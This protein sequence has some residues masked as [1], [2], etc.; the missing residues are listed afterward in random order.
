MGVILSLLLADIAVAQLSG[1]SFR[2]KF[3]VNSGQVSGSSDLN[4]FPV[5]VSVTDADLRSTGNGGNVE[6]PNGF[7][8]TFT[9]S[10]GTTRLDHQLE[11]YDASTGEV[12][13]WVRFPTLSATSDTEF[14]IYYGNSGI[15]T[16]QSAASTFDS[17]YQL[18]SHLNNSVNDNS[19]NGFTGTANATTAAPGFIGGG[20]SFGGGASDFISYTDD[21]AL[22][23]AGDI[24]I[25]M[26]VNTD[27]IN[28]PDLLTKGDFDDAY[29]AWFDFNGIIQFQINA[30]RLSGNG[31]IS[32]GNWT[33]L[34][35]VKSSGLG[36]RAIF[37][38]GA[39]DNSDGTTTAF[40]TNPDPLTISSSAF[41]FDGTID[42]VRISDVA[43]STDWISTEFNNQNAPAAFI[44][45][46]PDPP[47]LTNIE[48]DPQTFN[49]GGSPVFV[50][51]SIDIEHP[52][53][54]TLQ[55]GTVEIT[56]NQISSEDELLFTD[57]NGIT[58]S[59]NSGNGILS[60]S[61]TAS[62]ADYQ[63]ALRSIQYN[64]TNGTDPDQSTR[65]ISFTVNDGS[66]N[67]NTVNR[68]LDIIKSITDLSTDVPEVVFHFD[69][70]D[71]DGDLQTTDQPTDGSAIT[72]WGD[73]SDDATGS[74]IDL[75]AGALSGAE[76]PLFDSAFFGERGGLLWDGTDDG[77]E[78]PDDNS[79]NT[80]S[81]D[82]K[83]FAVIFRTGASTAGLQ[84]VYEQGAGTRGY[85]ISIK[86][87]QAYAYTWNKA[88][89]GAGD[90]NKSINL[91][92]VQPHE[93][94]IVIASHDAAQGPLADRTWSAS[95]NGGPLQTLNNT[96]VQEAHG[97]DPVIGKEDG[98]SDP[99]TFT[100][101]A[102]TGNFDGF[103]AELI[104]WNSALNGGQ[105]SSIYTFLDDKWGNIPPQLSSIENTDLDYTEGDPPTIITSNITVSDSDNTV[106]DSAYVTITE[107]FASTEDALSFTSAGNITG[108]F[109]TGTG[110]LTLKGRD[111]KANYQT[112]LRSVTY[113]NT[114]TVDPATALRQVDFK[115]FDWDDSSNAASRNINIISENSSPVISNIEG[116]T[117]PY[118]EGDGAVTVTSSIT[119]NDADNAEL[120]SADISITD[121]FTLGEDKLDFPDQNGI[122]GNFNSSTG[123][124]TLT[125]TASVT[126]YQTALRSVT[127]ENISSD[128]VEINRTISLSVNDGNSNSN[129]LSRDVSVTAVNTAPALSN[130][131]S[132]DLTFEGS[133]I[134]ITNTLNV[135]DPDD[136][137]L[138]SALV[139]I[140]EN[141]DNSQDSLRFDPIFGISGSWD[142]GTGVLKLTGTAQLSDYQAA[143]Q[144]VQ[145]DNFAGIP[146]GAQREI[147]FVASDGLAKSDTVK[148]FLNVTAVLAIPDATVWLRADLGITTSGSE[149]VEWADQTENGNDYSGNAGTG[150]RPSLVGSSTELNN[151]PAVNFSGDG[152]HFLDS[153]GH[154]N[155]ING[156][157]EFTMFI[158]IKSDQ[159]GTDSGFWITETPVG[160]DKTF[161][162]RY[163]D[164]GANNNG[165]FTNVV[166]T[167]ILNNDPDNQLESFSNLQT[168]NG[169]ILSLNW[170]SNSAYDI[171]VDGILNNPSAAGP[172][173]TGIIS[174]ATTAILGKGG[175]DQGNISWD[176]QIAEFILFSRNITDEERKTVEDYLSEKY[177]LPIRKIDPAD[178]GEAISADDTN[179]NFTTLTGPTVQE[180]VPGELSAGGTLVFT[181]PDGF[182]WNTG[183]TPSVTVSA[184]FGGNT[185][186][187]ASFTSI[188]ATEITFTINT[189]S[190]S[191]PGQ[192][193]FS[194]LQVRPTNGVLPNTGNI[195]NTGSTGLGGDT[196]YG[197][198]NMVAGARDSLVYLQQPTNTIADS[199]ISPAV[200]LQLADQFGNTVKDQGVSIDLALTSGSGT[201]S[202]TTPILTNSLGISEFS[203]LS[204]DQ[205]GTKQL[206]ASGTGLDNS[207]SSE[208]DILTAGAL[209]AFKIEREPSGNISTQQ[210]GQNF[211]I[212]ITAIDGSGNAVSSFDGT[213]V[214]NSNCTLG[215]GIG[216]TANF[217]S[218]VLSN[219]TVSLN[220]TGTCTI[221]AINSAGSESGSSNS[222]QIVPGPASE[223]TS[224]ITASPTVILNDGASTST[225]TVQIKDDQGNNLNSG[226]DDV[227]LTTDEGTLGSV[228]DNTDGTYT[229]ELTSS[230][231]AVTATI[232]GTVNGR[233]IA[234][235]AEVEF[236]AFSHIWESQLG[237]S[238]VASNWDDGDNWNSGTVPD[239]SSVVLIPANPAVG[240]EFPVVNV[241]N[242]T[243]SQVA[244]E[245][246]SEI[247]I[248]GSVNFIVSGNLSGGGS[249]LGSNS[250]SL[251][252]GGDLD[253]PELT[254]G[255]V[256]FNGSTD[257]T[258]ISP[259]NFRNMEIDNPGIINS[260]A[261]VTVTGTLSL[262]DG[263][264]LMP[265]GTNLIANNKSIGS[266][267]LR[268]Q[269][270]VSGITGWRML[271]A[272]V[273]SSIGDF[274]DGT[275]TQG[276][277]G[278]T[279]GNAP[280]DS[281]QPNVLH[282]DE[283]FPGTDNQRFR[284]PSDSSD[285]TVASQGMF[286]FFFGSIPEDDRY[287]NPLPDTLDVMGQEFEGTG[288]Q[289]DFNVTYTADADTGW[290]LVGNPYGATINWDDP[291]WTKTDIES[292]IYVWDPE[293]NGGNGEYLTWNG[294]TG[295]LGSGL[296]APFQGFWIKATS[297]GASLIVNEDAKTTGGDFTRKQN[298][299]TV[300]NASLFTLELN[301]EGLSRQ[302]DI[303]L[304]DNAR[305]GKDP[306]DAYIITPF[307]ESR[308]ELFTLLNDGIP[309]AINN[310]PLEFNTRYTLPLEVRGF[311]EGEPITS[312][313]QLNIRGIRNIPDNW[314][315]L[316]VDNETQ[317]EINLLEQ[318]SYSFNHST[319]EKQV[320]GTPGTRSKLVQK[321]K[322]ISSRF[323]LIIST[324][325]IE[326]NVPRRVFL[327]Q[328]YPNPFSES[329]TIEF[330]LPEETKVTLEIFD[331]IGR[332][333]ARLIDDETMS[334][335]E[336]EVVWTP[337]RIASGVY[338]YR[339]KTDNTTISEKMTFIK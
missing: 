109:D 218:G 213:V 174:N 158:V 276:Y 67:S 103:I 91:G 32:A 106:L 85:Q 94:Y 173:P 311:L 75:S 240:N 268:F 309:L 99:V 127:Y 136:T 41:P 251:T 148:R 57:Q 39:L 301:A 184:A 313:F 79:L 113:E 7:D 104:S 62:L 71:I 25:S 65:T 5:L 225:I 153:D 144:S 170:E 131:E 143:L 217:S 278:S 241:T 203:N 201:L 293:A 146:T 291:S 77:L 40:N 195:T 156:M 172:P 126:D 272:P 100:N 245:S 95:M 182:E 110:R 157:D 306:R 264:L 191:T 48:T 327:D 19:Q 287:N 18:V 138:D 22:D 124:L 238:D 30:D 220:D 52:F 164:S 98:T 88:E 294:T 253:I 210:A 318:N 329:A 42:E 130:I 101:P 281:L 180:G 167:G 116:S 235:E 123:V 199:T 232:T 189:A 33:Y 198:L 162:M 275:L 149:V 13:A 324:E 137:T 151:Q 114:N 337:S 200:R 190:N 84:V 222:F 330:G 181:A 44:T 89:W 10:D 178:G 219:K 299:N 304:S 333:V 147:S 112:V 317:Q 141:Y 186:L 118:T 261:D 15:T 334:P 227:Q 69:S 175:K 288:T 244:M 228:I 273:A 214:L 303:M 120:Q 63:T 270:I 242:T 108:S 277:P 312:E 197:T 73:R 316:L 262:T 193:D 8:I 122:T 267:V 1:F 176:G 166:K 300:E 119:V 46:I 332:Q 142:T 53:T 319:Q 247:Q 61:G 29:G 192:L 307:S 216:T 338:L 295:T 257:Q 207:V 93:S 49:A 296:I 258:V 290:N 231:S 76:E 163:D 183:A 208:F 321:E 223:S 86:D 234:D 289:V 3:Q 50:T 285:N 2:K 56:G 111:S 286:V 246:G 58:G 117:L 87:G 279:L 27:A 14:F 21:P 263:E 72:T 59:F 83:S 81:F 254:V 20:R 326:E 252:V 12:I 226:G 302:T 315:V 297:P 107:N 323:T 221:T 185:S 80:S 152:D 280:E 150:T 31:S 45:E 248:T 236:A 66:N 115:V 171:F 96:D 133:P 215:T 35:F 206:T 259:H 284:A 125:G 305:E 70:Q 308:L 38:D 154:T 335:G 331:V 47:V 90:Q 292:T 169:Q 224:L 336:H 28:G 74:G 132:S 205:T 298:P 168:T 4:N 121:N 11:S 139:I 155:Y 237:E 26:W 328:S 16:D 211:N 188:T 165:T 179:V 266:G 43:R 256:I 92:P 239:A 161:T 255:N 202:G 271:S 160:E 6:S 9:S 134:E 249:L 140:S 37:I 229:A 36:G 260:T 128:P 209:A 51:S 243:V 325:E 322:S 55:G 233:S 339:L 250:D 68:D 196:N 34:T 102:G 105:I 177:N 23:I 283:T 274:L 204:I 159:T 64:N 310:L 314:L 97:G 135:S 54:N 269:R 320:M 212:K 17:N 265:S 82:E 60:L 282:Y 230:T 78:P 145:Y 187:D 194:N 24:T 129:T